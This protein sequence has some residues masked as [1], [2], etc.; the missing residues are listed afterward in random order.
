MVASS[1]VSV[2]QTAGGEVTARRKAMKLK[3]AVVTLVIAAFGWAA[4]SAGQEVRPV[5]GP[6]TGVVTVTGSVDIGNMPSVDI[7]NMPAVR[8]DG[9]WRVR[10]ASPPDV[11]V[12]GP[13]FLT[14]RGQ[15]AVT[16]SAGHAED[17]QV[18]ELATSGWARVASK[19]G[20]RRWVNFAHAQAVEEIKTG[21]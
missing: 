15:Y 1:I 9:D 14:V 4:M 8:Q 3:L 5:P 11:R 16:W 17:V 6:G 7:R 18:L 19:S 20:S 21:R 10:F 2:R 12:A 13:E